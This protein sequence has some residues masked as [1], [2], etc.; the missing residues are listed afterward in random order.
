MTREEAKKIIDSELAQ[1]TTDE[2][3]LKAFYGMYAE[4]LIPLDELKE[5]ADI[6]GYELSDDFLKMSEDERKA[7]GD[8]K[9]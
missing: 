8:K 7:L 1:G 6:L 3:L 9:N 5:L 4:N 2:E